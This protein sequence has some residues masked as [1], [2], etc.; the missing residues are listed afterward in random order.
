MLAMNQGGRVAPYT[1]AETAEASTWLAYVDGVLAVAI[2][3][4][5]AA[6]VEAIDKAQRRAGL[7]V[8]AAALLAEIFDVTPADHLQFA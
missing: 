7:S 1:A 5:A 6:I 8:G 2:G 3:D 4:P